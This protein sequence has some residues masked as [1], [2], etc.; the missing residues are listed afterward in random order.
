[1]IIIYGWRKETKPV[2]QIASCYCYGCQREKTWEHWRE[3]EWVTFFGM[4]T[5][6]FLDK[7]YATCPGC[8]DSIQLKG[9]LRQVFTPETDRRIVEEAIESHQ[10]ANK[11]EVQK[12]FLRAHRESSS[13]P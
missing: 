12:R 9:K 8:R 5:I 4:K 11:S 6:P 3:T 10:L 13:R 2:A 1:M 7:R